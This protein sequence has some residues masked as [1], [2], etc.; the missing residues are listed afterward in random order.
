MENKYWNCGDEN[1]SD[2]TEIRICH[3]DKCNL[4][5]KTVPVDDKEPDPIEDFDSILKHNNIQSCENSNFWT[6]WSDYNSMDNTIQNECY[7]TKIDI[8]EKQ[9]QYKWMV[10]GN[11]LLHRQETEWVYGLPEFKSSSFEIFCFDELQLEAFPNGDVLCKQME[12]R[13]CCEQ[14]HEKTERLNS[15]KVRLSKSI[16]EIVPPKLRQFFR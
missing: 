16:S 11:I 15:R 14:T 12:K 10:T 4:V 7:P 3:N 1:W 8:R 9:N 13:Y 2:S 5:K 6:E